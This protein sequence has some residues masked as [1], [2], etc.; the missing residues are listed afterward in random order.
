MGL[1]QVA[2][3]EAVEEQDGSTV[4]SLPTAHRVK[5]ESRCCLVMLGIKVRAFCMLGKCLTAQ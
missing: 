1:E 5:Q 4:P 3:E 2:R